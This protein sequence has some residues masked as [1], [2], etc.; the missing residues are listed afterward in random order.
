V[1]CH[2]TE[3]DVG[4]FLFAKKKDVGRFMLKRLRS[5]RSVGKNMP[6]IPKSSVGLL[7]LTHAGQE[8]SKDSTITNSHANYS[9]Y[10]GDK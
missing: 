4:R 3:S 1:D 5:N 8:L 9:P 6:L 7:A 2:G 10:R